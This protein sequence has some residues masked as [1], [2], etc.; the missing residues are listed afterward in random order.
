MFLIHKRQY[1]EI[2]KEKADLLDWVFDLSLRYGVLS[3]RDKYLLK[4]LR[5]DV[6][7][8]DQNDKLIHAECLP[9]VH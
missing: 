8:Y 7:S 5:D 3:P 2:D 6:L 1:L 4:T 9:D